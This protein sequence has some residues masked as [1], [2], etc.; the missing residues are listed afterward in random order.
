[1]PKQIYEVVWKIR[2]LE[3][4]FVTTQWKVFDSEAEA[5]AYGC[6]WQN[7]ANEGLSPCERVED[8]YC[9]QFMGAYPVDEVDGYQ[10]L[11]RNT[12]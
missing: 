11:L 12:R 5:Q 1:M 7:E 9:Y 10:I 3:F 8:G 6:Q 4:E 2:C